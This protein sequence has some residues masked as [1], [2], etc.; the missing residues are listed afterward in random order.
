MPSECPSQDPSPSSSTVAVSQ[1]FNRARN[2]T[3][4]A[5]SNFS[6]VLGNQYNYYNQERKVTRYIVG[7][8]EEEAEYEQFPEVLRSQVIAFQDIHSHSI[9]CYD[10]AHQKS[11]E[12]AR[13]TVVAGELAIGGGVSKCIVVQY[14]GERAEEA[15]KRDFRQFGGIRRPDNTQLV[16]INLSS[17]PMLILT[18]DLVPLAHL[19][20]RVG[21]MVQAYLKALARQMGCW[22]NDTL[23]M[24]RS[25]GVFCRGPRGPECRI[26]HGFDFEELP[27][28]AELLKEDVLLRYLSLRSRNQDRGVVQGLSFAPT[29]VS[30]IKVNRPTVISTLTGTILAVGSGGWKEEWRTCLGERQELANRTTRFTMHHNRQRLELG[31]NWSEANEAWIAQALS[32]FH[33]H[34]ISPEEDL[35]EYKLVLPKTLEGTPSKSKAK[36]RRRRKCPPIYLFV[37]PLSTFIFWS[38]NPDGRNRITTDLCNYL[39]LPISLSPKCMEYYWSTEIYKALRAYQIARDFDPNTPEFAQRNGYSIYEI[40]KKPPPSGNRFEEIKD[41]EP[42]TEIPLRRSV[43]PEELGD[44]Y[45]GVLFGDV[46][47]EDPAANTM[48]QEGAVKAWSRFIPTFSW[49]ALEDSDIHAAGF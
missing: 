45:L 35:G 19:E 29:G 46:Q 36:R 2:V 16:A 24:D 20:S 31:L 38:F 33:A 9:E 34:G 32:I 10:K 5:Y 15:W 37:P 17:I 13:R 12:C 22:G 44:T 30:Q 40:I 27:S 7:T 14:S 42:S 48:R 28:D 6:T 25:R 18:G 47:P 11:V 21:K 8:Q 41:F 1:Y 23:W 39:G 26:L 4:G 43:H 49:A 3:I